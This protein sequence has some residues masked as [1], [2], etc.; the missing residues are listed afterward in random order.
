MTELAVAALRS[1]QY[2]SIFLEQ[3]KHFPDFHPPRLAS[4]LVSQPSAKFGFSPLFGLTLNEQSAM[5]R[6]LSRLVAVGIA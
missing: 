2:P 4:R 3:T 1:H 5:M 6:A